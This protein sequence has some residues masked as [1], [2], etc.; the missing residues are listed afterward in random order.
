MSL[1]ALTELEQSWLTFPFPALHHFSATRCR[2]VGKSSRQLDKRRRP[3]GE[4]EV[5]MENLPLVHDGPLVWAVPE[6]DWEVLTCG[7]RPRLDPPPT[8]TTGSPVCADTNSS[9]GARG[10]RLGGGG[11]SSS[12]TNPWKVEKVRGHIPETSDLPASAG[13]EE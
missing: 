1:A 3:P 13:D 7:S 11:L 12:K 4:P 5:W 6:A 10:A 2:K 8:A 9:M